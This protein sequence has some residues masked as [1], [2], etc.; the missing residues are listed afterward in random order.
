MIKLL[1]I[2]A[3]SSLLIFGSA[4]SSRAFLLPPGPI[5]PTID[6]P[7]DAMAV[8]ENVGATAQNVAAQAQA[9]TNTA[10]AKVKAAKKKYM[11]KFTGW[12]G[13][14]FQKKEKQDMPG[15]KEIEESKIADIYDA[16][17]VKQALYELF[18]AYPVDCDKGADEYDQC[19]AYE[20][21]AQEFYEDTVIEIYTSSRQLETELET[22]TQE[23]DKLSTTFAG[24]SS[25]ADGAE[26][27]DDENG[28][29][30]NAF[31]AYETMDSI[32]KITQEV[33]AMK[34]QYEAALLLHNQITPAGYV[35]KK[36]REAKEKAAQEKTSFNTKQEELK[37]A[38]TGIIS[39]QETL[40]F[41]QLGFITQA[42]FKL[43]E[44]A[45]KQATIE[46]D[47]DEDY[48]Y[49]PSLY[50]NVTFGEATKPN[51]DSPFAGNEANIQ[52][53]E[54]ITPVYETAQEALEVHNL[55]QALDSYQEIFKSYNQYKRL[56]Q[57]SIEAVAS[58]DQCVIQY[59]SRRYSSPETVWKG[60]MPDAAVNDYDARKGLSGWAIKAF[61]L[62][63]S[64]EST[65]IEPE[66]LGTIEVNMDVDINDANG[67][68]SVQKE[69]E[70]KGNTGLTDASQTEEIE[71]STRE[72]QMISF[73][74][75][76]EAAQMLVEDQYSSTPKWGTPNQK[77]PI[78]NDQINFYNQ[79][80]SGKYGNIKDY[81]Q[82]YDITS[83]IVEIAYPLN[84]IL[85]EDEEERSN[86]RSGLDRLAAKLEA[87][88]ANSD[89]ATVLES[90]E[91]NKNDLLQQ[92]LKNKQSQVQNLE[93]RKKSLQT[94]LDRASSL[95]SDYSEQLNTANENQ[96]TAQA[97]IDTMNKQLKY[98]EERRGEMED[99]M[100]KQSDVE[101][102]SQTYEI[103]PETTKQVHST[104]YQENTKQK[105]LFDTSSAISEYKDK[106][107]K[108]NYRA[109]QQQNIE[110][111]NLQPTNINS[112]PDGSLS[113]Y[114]EEKLVPSTS[115]SNE[116]KTL[117]RR[118]PFSDNSDYA[119]S[120]LSKYSLSHTLYFG[121]QYNTFNY[122]QEKAKLDAELDAK[123]TETTE[124][125][126]LETTDKVEE[127]T[128]EAQTA[129]YTE[130]ETS[131]QEVL[132]L[133]DSEEMALT[134]ELIN[135]Q[136][137]EIA[138]NKE[139]SAS[140][141]VQVDSKNQEVN[142]LTK[143]IEAI[144]ADIA[145]VE[146]NYVAQ[147]QQ[148][149]Q[150]YNQKLEEA[151]KYIE[152]KRRAK[153]TLDLLSY[154]KDKIG[155]PVAGVDGIIPPFSLLNVLQVANGL[156]EDTRSYAI[157]LVDDTQNA[158]MN[159]GEGVYIGAYG[160]K[161]LSLHQELMTKLKSLPI[162][163]LQEFSSSIGRY[164][165]TQSIIKPLTTM[166]QKA[167][168]EKA[169][170]GDSCMQADSEYFVGSYGKERDF[171]APKNSLKEYLPPLREIVY[172]DDV[173]YDNVEKSADGGVSKDGFLNSGGKYPSIW[174]LILNDKVFV[175]KGVDLKALLSEGGETATFMRGGRYPCRLD[176]RI[177]DVNNTSGNFV[178]YTEKALSEDA[179]D[180]ER[181]YRPAG[182]YQLPECNEIIVEDN[183]GIFDKLYITVRDK[184][185]D[186]TGS[187]YGTVF[188]AYSGA[189]M[190]SGLGSFLK[191][192]NSGL[193]FNDAPNTVFTRL[194]KMADEQKDK[195]TDKNMR[196]IIYEKT[197][198]NHNQIG[199]FLSFVEQE[200]SYRQALEEMKLSVDEA[201]ADLFE[202]FDKIGFVPS[203]DYDL[204]KQSDYDL[205][206]ET[207]TRYKNT[208][209]N[210]GTEGL[211]SIKASQNEVIE[212][213]VNKIK[214][215]FT[216]LRKDK[217]AYISLNDATDSG[218]ELDEQIKT[219]E[220]NRKATSEYKKKADEEFEK[221]INSYPIPFCAA[222]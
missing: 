24:G 196:D 71:K 147:V 96:F 121:A 186:V 36:E 162:E 25:G 63:K 115:T 177:I 100:V 55:I 34:V 12:M 32:L 126:T 128:Q 94:Q 119:P 219:E 146:K 83:L 1:K 148:I 142:S 199:N 6:G 88:N 170:V 187:A 205:T 15:S 185:E 40:M 127:V 54:K 149:E 117:F 134:K 125:Q 50:G 114:P 174:K 28:A 67:F 4:L 171:M 159:L 203:A 7:T 204:A 10:T 8:V 167:L 75:G 18:L 182:M 64:E 47:D 5:T 61:E 150:A 133:E 57:K 99:N 91:K 66:N 135:Q 21:K 84:D 206:K 197:L 80:L 86:N 209:L 131:E 104:E 166:F 160:N 188:Q 120:V 52:E 110:K 51:I 76:A 212:E 35:S 58:A 216:A 118:R 211:T 221:Q 137:T 31:N 180:E 49:N 122:A 90:L 19:R 72:S 73:N 97:Q 109:K 92:A 200:I 9:Y 181:A 65:P 157:Q 222:Y 45:S 141:K 37:F 16:N 102:T 153:E 176:D 85:T 33:F 139:V 14:L 158:I 62:A 193:Y 77:F 165:K 145:S 208:L 79:Y 172:F 168:I 22:L 220:V 81:L 113:L 179:T 93:N 201:K 155:L 44:E 17:S 111:Q 23:V 202:Q 26:S 13:G 98:Q 2:I 190:H 136:Q 132:N 101:F 213:R 189:K 38:S 30:K 56:H 215:I 143:Q 87:E 192:T 140:L 184:I 41:G 105:M 103:T 107:S 210:E 53:L 39:R 48:V 116:K 169:C 46:E 29:W 161:I 178:V 129:E 42:D 69:L 175:E 191:A 164:A 27:G 173:D 183:G 218:S 11:D 70:Q 194:S 207:L 195:V 152:A 95:L 163:G 214:N 124:Y 217:E 198:F 20:T 89:P 154:Y 106:M 108:L 156:T 59:L 78:W 82:Q 138:K 151:K 68:Q 123:T 74:I 144:D 3:L 43:K 60:T 112:N 130:S